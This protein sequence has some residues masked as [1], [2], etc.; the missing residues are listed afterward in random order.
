M[1]TNYGRNGRVQVCARSVG[2]LVVMSRMKVTCSSGLFKFGENSCVIL[3][4]LPA[5]AAKTAM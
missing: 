1:E 3:P 2:V 4:E 5:T